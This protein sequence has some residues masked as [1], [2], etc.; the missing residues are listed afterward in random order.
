MA[1]EYKLDLFGLLGKL[2]KQDAKYYSTLS[3][4]EIKEISPFVIMRWLTGANDI[5]QIFLLN[6]L[7]NPFVFSLPNKQNKHTEL[8]L[9]LMTLCCSGKAHRY[10]YVKTK[11]KKTTSTPKTLDVVKEFFQYSSKDAISA[12]KLISN[13]DVISFA[14][15]LGRQPPEISAIKKEL[16]KRNT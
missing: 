2:S 12:L 13:D 8:L 3:D 10:R 14:E 5:Q 1:K 11:T 16:K 7:V 4:E 9:D 6:E 15:Q